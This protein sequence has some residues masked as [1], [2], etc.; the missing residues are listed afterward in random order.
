MVEIIPKPA[1]KI[2]L[3]QNLLLLFSIVV[4]IAAVCGYFLLGHFQEKAREEIKRVEEDLASTETKERKELESQILKYQKKIDNF[5]FLF[6]RH[7][8]SSNF[9]EFLEEITHPKVWLSDLK[10]NTE[11]TTCNLSG[12]AEN[13]VVLGQQLIIFQETNE[14]IKT[15]L[16]EIFLREGKIYFTFNLS[17]KPEIFKF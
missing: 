5:T 6:N 9:F 13:F 3:W 14:I 1:E 4:L 15:D 17:L 12:E 10:I 16:P 11:E 7:K 2:P 8:A